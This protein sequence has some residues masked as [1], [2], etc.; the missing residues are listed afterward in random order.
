MLEL[1]YIGDAA[2]AEIVIGARVPV[3]LTSRGDTVFA[4]VASIAL[5]VLTRLTP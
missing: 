5:A 1:E 2:C 3:V 4:R